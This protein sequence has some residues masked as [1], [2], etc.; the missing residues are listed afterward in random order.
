MTA[1]CPGVKVPL[2]ET[3]VAVRVQAAPATFVVQEPGM[4]TKFVNVV[5][6]ET[7]WLTLPLLVMF[8]VTLSSLPGPVQA[9]GSLI[10]AASR[11]TVTWNEQV[12]VLLRASVAVQLTVVTPTLKLVAEGGVQATVTPGQLSETVGGL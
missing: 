6:S 8:S 7:V 10:E 1:V 5:V 3:P 4:P 9:S 2:K 11:L 12:A